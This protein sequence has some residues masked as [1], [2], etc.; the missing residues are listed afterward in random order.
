MRAA[1][2]AAA[3][4]AAVALAAEVTEARAAAASEAHLRMPSTR[5]AAMPNAFD[6]TGGVTG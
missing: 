3:A 5:V 2:A 4:A 1:A 6:R